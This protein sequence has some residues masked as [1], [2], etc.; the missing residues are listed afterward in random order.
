[1]R[2]NRTIAKFLIQLGRIEVFDFEVLN[3]PKLVK[4]YMN[5]GKEVIEGDIFRIIIRWFKMVKYSFGQ[6]LLNWMVV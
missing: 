4:G 5:R 2:P 1:M 6:M 3:V